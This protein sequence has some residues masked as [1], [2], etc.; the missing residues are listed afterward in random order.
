MNE[1]ILQSVAIVWVYMSAWFLYAWAAKR[2]DVADFAW[3]AGFP[4]LAITLM[5]LNESSSVKGLILTLLVTIWGLRLALHIYPRLKKK[6]EDFR[7]ATMRKAWGKWAT[8]RSY[9]Q[10]FMLQGLFLLMISAST[11]VVINGESTFSWINYLGIAI[12]I[13]GFYFEAVGDHQLQQFIKNPS[14][15][16][17]IMTTGLWK[18]TRHPNYFGEV[19]QWWGLWLLVIGVQYWQFAVISPLTI[20][21]LIYF[22]SGIP[23]LEKKYQGN[24]DY[25]RYAKKTSKFFP[26]PPR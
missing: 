8:I 14:S 4:I 5:Q 6:D 9:L 24:K 2:N 21:I 15:K 19:I 23:L 10:V 22:V 25:E 18:Y 7:Y 1:I 13:V 3:G 11:I 20:T 26:L 17:R 16:G 12:W